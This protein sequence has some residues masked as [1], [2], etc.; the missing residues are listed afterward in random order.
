[1]YVAMVL[2]SSFEDG[3]FACLGQVSNF[4]DSDKAMQQAVARCWDVYDEA[5]QQVNT[6][7]CCVFLHDCLLYLIKVTLWVCH[8]ITFQTLA[9]GPESLLIQGC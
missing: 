1:M 3:T 9:V 6:G 2:N 8:E 5:V 4:F 7:K